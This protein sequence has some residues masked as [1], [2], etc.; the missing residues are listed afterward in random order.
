VGGIQM[1]L[2]AQKIHADLASVGITLEMHGLPHVA[3]LPQIIGG[4]AALSIGTWRSDY[5]D[6]SDFLPAFAPGGAVAAMAGWPGESDAPARALAALSRAAAVQ[7]DAPRRVALYRQAQ[8]KLAAIGPYVTLFA[9]AS[10][11]A[12]RSNVQGASFNSVWGLD[13]FAIHKTS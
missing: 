10:P 1:S 8:R 12:Y 6:A 2:L 13:F 5:P 7:M 11:Y 4:R 9:P 3:A